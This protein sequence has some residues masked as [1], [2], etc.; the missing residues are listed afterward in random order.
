ML[1]VG[2]TYLYSYLLQTIIAIDY[3]S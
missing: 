1:V 3:H 2:G